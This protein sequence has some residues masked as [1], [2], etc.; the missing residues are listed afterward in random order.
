MYQ[1][2]KDSYIENML[3]SANP[4]Q[5]IIIAYDKAIEF[6]ELAIEAIDAGLD[7]INNLI[8]KCEYITK[9][10][11]AVAI[12]HDSLNFEKGGSVAKDLSYFYR[13]I[14][15]GLLIANQKNDKELLQN[16]IM[17]L[18]GVKK[19]WEELERREYGSKQQQQLPEAAGSSV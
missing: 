10:T 18:S 6:M 2:L 14:L 9:A 17:M 1:N 19:A 13:T 16:M 11:E 4:L 3:F 7:D 8:K 5:L 12:L 15:E